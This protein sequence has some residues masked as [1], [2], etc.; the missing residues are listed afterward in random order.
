MKIDQKEFRKACGNFATGVTIVTTTSK[1]G[2][3]Q[4][5]T[6]NGFMS[7][8]LDPALIVVSIGKNQK[9]HDILKDSAV[10]GVSI[11]SDT[12]TDVSNHFAGWPVENLSI[13]FSVRSE[14]PYL[15]DNIAYFIA[16]VVNAIDAGDHTLF[17]GEVIQ[18][19]RNEKAP[20]L[21][22]QGGYRHLK[23]PC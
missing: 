11:L 4:G 7:V 3:V 8:S 14:I 1:A 21:Y 17:I 9:M 6:V 13:E 15:K 18:F 23:G 22:Y 20:L 10:Y 16:K 12:Q 19:E 2:E 5:M